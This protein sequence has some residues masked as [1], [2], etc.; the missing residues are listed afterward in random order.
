MRYLIIIFLLILFFDANAQKIKIESLVKEKHL[1]KVVKALEKS[2]ARIT[3]SEFSYPVYCDNYGNTYTLRIV[4]KKI[5]LITTE[6][7]Y[8]LLAT[9]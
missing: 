4:R 6:E 1:T 7:F 3:D 9:K 8:E 5:R 2:N